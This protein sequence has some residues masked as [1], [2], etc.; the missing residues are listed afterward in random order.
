MTS[1]RSA[2]RAWLA[3][4][5]AA[6]VL[7]PYSL[8]VL[9]FELPL[10]PIRGVLRAV[11]L[12]VALATLGVVLRERRAPRERVL[13]VAFLANMVPLFAAGAI[14]L[15]ASAVFFTRRYEGAKLLFLCLAM[16]A[17]SLRV[18]GAVMLALLVEIL[19]I[20]GSL[21][22]P[23]LAGGAAST[24]IYAG[25]SY[26][27]LTF[28]MRGIAA[29]DRRRE[30]EEDL[31]MSGVVYRLAEAGAELSRLP[32]APR[33]FSAA[34]DHLLRIVEGSRLACVYAPAAGGLE[35]RAR[36]GDSTEPPAMRDV[37][38]PLPAAW[39][40]G[41]RIAWAQRL[42][43]R[44]PDGSEAV[45]V[46]SAQ[47]EPPQALQETLRGFA[48]CLSTALLV[49]DR[50]QRVREGEAQIAH[51][52]ALRDIQQQI[53]A[54]LRL[55]RVLDLVLAH[56]SELLKLEMGSVSLLDPVQQVYVL[57]RVFGVP[58][59]QAGQ[60]IPRGVGLTGLV[61]ARKE[62]VVMADYEAFERPVASVLASGPR[63][64]IGTPITAHGMMIGVL[65]FSSRTPHREYSAADRHLV[66]MLA[67]QAAIAIENAR[68]YAELIESNKLL[69]DRVRE[70]TAQLEAAAAEW[71]L[72]FDSVEVPMLLL[73]LDGCVRR[74]NRAVRAQ[75]GPASPDPVGRR[76]EE[77]PPRPPWRAAAE[78]AR[79]V[80]A[81]GNSTLARVDEDHQH[82][83]VSASLLEPGGARWL[84]LV[85]R[86]VTS[87]VALE[88]SLRRSQTMSAMGALVGGVAHEVRNPLFAI[89]A[90]VD[91]F[92]ARFGGDSQSREYVQVLRTEVDR[93]GR[94][95]SELLDYGKP[96][97]L[98]LSKCSVADIVHASLETCRALASERGVQVRVELS[99][100][101]PLLQVDA[102]RMAQVFSNL[103]ENAI[104]HSPRSGEVVLR[105]QAVR[106]GGRTWVAVTVEDC[107]PGF[108]PRDLERVFEPFFT[109]RR[110]GTGLGLSIVQ[111][112]VEQHDGTIAASNRAEGG[113]RLV[114]SL[115]V[116]A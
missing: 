72:T 57:E 4:A 7:V 94:L 41:E 114:V 83:Q 34:V 90:T 98:A 43:F 101:L 54:E 12:A 63:S 86:D 110:G 68:L 111:R 92:Q 80:A 103:L 56:G 91:A 112:I 105:S 96:A 109:K 9:V 31:W 39:I 99:E 74:V 26:V 93:L 28:R 66:E 15:G 115:P 73:D 46:Y 76:L 8:I 85:A 65:I 17:P 2:E 78:L 79:A 33:I 100:S 36:A 3:T 20:A 62:T 21:D 44:Q 106:E 27:L 89:S 104:H 95:M 64:G 23:F 10:S 102:Q 88:E 29:E 37:A 11:Q 81:H 22:E 53:D 87:E 61:D 97:A 19:A 47:S 25:I 77:L 51:M 24:V 13:V 32:D 42:P 30:L 82:W 59:L 75:L 107:G 67:N 69:E 60:V 1:A 18:G 113:A 40:E 71:Q 49:A 5:T 45:L 55:P 108:E 16:I 38:A 116:R 84:F 6:T 48:H 14:T 58:Q 52:S 50:N 35:L 70:R